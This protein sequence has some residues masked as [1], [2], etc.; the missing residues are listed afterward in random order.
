MH[1]HIAQAHAQE[2]HVFVLGG[3]TFPGV[4]TA[5][6]KSFSG[7]MASSLHQITVRGRVATCE[8]NIVS[9]PPLGVFLLEDFHLER[10]ESFLA[11]I[12]ERWASLSWKEF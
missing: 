12:Q 1:L 10:E 8:F 3:P 6:P 2:P 5:T 9:P 4:P 11:H 7:S